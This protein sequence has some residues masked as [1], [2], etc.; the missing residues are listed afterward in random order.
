MAALGSQFLQRKEDRINSH[1]L[2][3]IASQEARRRP[4]WSVQTMQAILLCEFYGR[5][6]GSRVVVR[7]SEPFQS[8]YSRVA[9]PHTLINSDSSNGISHKPW[10][11]WIV[12][13]SRRRLLAACF[14]LDIH[15]S[16][17][18]EHSTVHHFTTATP[19]IPLTKPTQ[20]LWAAQSLEAWEG[21]RNSPLAQFDP[22][23]L[24]NEE[25]TASHIN[26]A[27]P[28]DLAVYVASEALR[29][30]RRS[31]TSSM[32]LSADLDL[33]LSKRMHDLFPGSAV[34]NTYLAL[35]H[36]PLRDL[37]AVSGD[38]W[39]FSRKI[40][41]KDD[42][43]RRKANVRLWCSDPRA[44]AASIFASKAL[45]IFFD[46]NNNTPNS[47]DSTEGDQQEED[48]WSMSDIS[49]YWAMY[50]CALICW[51]I[52]HRTARGALA[53]GGD[54]NEENE[55][56]GWLRTMAG[57]SPEAAVQNVRARREA[58]GLVTMVR[59]RL[60]SEAA[61]GKSK[62]LVDAVRVLGDLAGNP[63]RGRF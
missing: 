43:Q 23:S 45:L 4:Q 26:T 13:E 32:G 41:D 2:H 38:T 55:A 36:T 12:H 51:S 33:N 7:A 25:I 35:H 11:E 19:P 28:L 6:R 10:D 24:D 59:R 62:L 18:H 46:T 63:N 56:K 16:M 22:A 57:L 53:Q 8:L 21:L 34:A 5:F 48:G 44:G 49:N 42:F 31:P 40:L 29:L 58:L 52:S 54:D 27:P 20:H 9:T 60:E 37:L 15:T 14:I 39:I 61:G 1:T 3:S 17:Y 47:E 50:V 30:P